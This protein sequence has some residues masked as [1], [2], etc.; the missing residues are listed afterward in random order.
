MFSHPKVSIETECILGQ[1]L[2]QTQDINGK[3]KELSGLEEKMCL[4]WVLSFEPY[5]TVINDVNKIERGWLGFMIIVF[6][7][8]SS[9][10]IF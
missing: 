5:I 10:S 8:N 1:I 9:L 2:E 7:C 4:C 3:P 6:S